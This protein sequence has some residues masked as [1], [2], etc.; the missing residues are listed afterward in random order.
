[1]KKLS[2]VILSATLSLFLFGCGNTEKL[3]TYYDGMM[4]FQG[5]ISIITE[6]LDLIDENKTQAPAL[7]CDQLDKL[8]EQFK[9]MS[10]LEVPKNFSGCEELA[11]DAY[12]Y[13]QEADRLYKEW[14]ADPE[15]ADEQLVDMAKQ[16][17][18]RALTR[19]N[20]IS[21]ILQ[22]GIPEGEGVTITEE[23]AEDFKPVQDSNTQ[24]E[25]EEIG[26]SPLE[27]EDVEEEYEEESGENEFQETENALN[28]GATE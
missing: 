11:D 27:E 12:T 23:D 9:L 22:G 16:N 6:T 14:A 17:Y 19:V 3:E 26:E 10:E 13:M 20:Y 18:D 25:T 21:I 8:T 7:V 5:N 15:N 24:P 28:N 2:I 1:M 4:A